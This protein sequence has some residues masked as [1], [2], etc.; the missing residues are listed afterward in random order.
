MLI[1]DGTGEFLRSL[2]QVLALALLISWVLAI[3]VTPALC[4]WFLTDSG[5]AGDAAEAEAT[6]DTAMY[7]FYRRALQLLLKYRMAFVGA[8]LLSL[9]AAVQIFGLVNIIQC[10]IKRRNSL[11]I[12]AFSP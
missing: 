4:Y 6:Y 9:F 12:V 1:S 5:G 3:S 11:D 2:G 7:Q 10:I 8:M